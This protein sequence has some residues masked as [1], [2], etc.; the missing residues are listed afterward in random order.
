MSPT[1]APFFWM[2]VLVPTVVPCERKAMSPQNWPSLEAE[3]LRAGVQRIHHAAREILRRRGD[4]GGEELAGAIDDRAIGEGTAYVDAYQIAHGSMVMR[5][6][7][8]IERHVTTSEATKRP[9][10]R[11]CLPWAGRRTR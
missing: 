11:A 2:M 4:L 6:V 5:A 3:G 8:M 7:V 9:A 1:R 10:P